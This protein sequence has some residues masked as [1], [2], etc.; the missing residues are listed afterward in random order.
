ML[1]FTMD[2]REPTAVDGPKSH[3]R[4]HIAVHLQCEKEQRIFFSVQLVPVSLP[5]PAPPSVDDHDESS[6]NTNLPAD[7]KNL[8]TILHIIT[9]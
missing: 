4:P 5:H 9:A 2:Q 7:P 8:M 6:T 3:V 1:N